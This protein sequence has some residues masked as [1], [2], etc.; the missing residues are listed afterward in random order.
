MG[1]VAVVAV[2]A[3]VALIADISVIL[4]ISLIT[5][6]T[7]ISSHLD[8]LM[9]FMDQLR[10]Q[11]FPILLFAPCGG[12]EKRGLRGHLALRQRASRPLQSPF[13][14]ALESPDRKV[15]CSTAVQS[16]CYN[17]ISLVK[18]NIVLCYLLLKFGEHNAGIGDMSLVGINTG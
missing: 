6:V 8:C 13:C 2:V 17:E 11:G 9:H 1:F 18:Q 5:V 12:W 15:S 4:F 16:M 3:L 7:V 10:I 14:R